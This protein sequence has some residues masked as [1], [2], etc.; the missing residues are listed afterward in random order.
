MKRKQSVSD[1]LAR[2][3]AAR[4]FE[5][6]ESAPAEAAPEGADDYARRTASPPPSPGTPTSPPPTLKPADEDD[7][8]DDYLTR[9]RKAKER[10]KKKQG[11]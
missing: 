7:D 8:G 6:E 1:T 5:V 4:K 10:G 9:M 3:K 11:D 2:K